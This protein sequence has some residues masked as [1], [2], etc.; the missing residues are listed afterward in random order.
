MLIIHHDRSTVAQT[1]PKKGIWPQ[2]TA[3]QPEEMSDR[4]DACENRFQ[5]QSLI[6]QIRRR[7]PDHT[8]RRAVEPD[9]AIGLLVADG[10]N[11]NAAREEAEEGPV[12]SCLDIAECGHMLVPAETQPAREPDIAGAMEDDEPHRRF[13]ALDIKPI[14]PLTRIHRAASISV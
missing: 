10:E 1:L 5:P 13:A 9:E 11:A 7:H 2:S 3:A 14:I 12:V 4:L 6:A 8:P